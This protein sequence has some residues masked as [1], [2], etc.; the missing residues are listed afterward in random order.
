MNFDNHPVFQLRKKHVRVGIRPVIDGRR[1]GVRES[2]E[3]QTMQMAKKTADLIQNTLRYSDGMPVE[4]VI[5]DICIGGA[6]EA[7]ACMEKFKENNVGVS[8][9]VTPCWCYGTEVMDITPIIPKAVWGFNGT[10]RPGAVYLAAAL[11]GYNQLGVP[12]FGIYGKDVQES[13]DSSIPDDVKEKL[14]LFTKAAIAAMEMQGKSYLS[15]GAV[16]MGIAGSVVD[17]HFIYDYL[18]MKSEFVDMTE[19]IRRI[20]EKIYDSEEFNK[21]IKWVAANCRE[22][23][24]PND[25]PVSGEQRK[26]EWETVVKMTMIFRDLMVGNPKLAELGFEEEALG[27]NAIAAGF[28]GQRQWTDFMPNGDFLEAILNSSFDWNGIRE[29]YIVATENDSLNGICMLFGLLLTN[30]AQIFSDV[31]T[32]W[33]PEAVQ[34]VG[35][36]KLTGLAEGGIIH[37]INSGSSALDGTGKQRLDGKPAIKPFWEITEKEA[38]DCLEATSWCP[39]IREYFRGGGFSSHFLTEG[40]MPVTM[41]RINIIHGLGP[42]LQIAEG[43]TVELDPEIDAL[44]QKRTNPTWPT[45]WFVPKITGKGAF[46]DVYSV[47][48]NWGANHAA[49][50]Y[51][52]IGDKLITLA[53]ILRIPVY[54]HNIERDRIFRPAAWN[55][56]GTSDAESADFAACKSFGPLY[57]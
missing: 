15:V 12:A 5:A 14:L 36:K 45:T 3:A 16:S 49:V 18:G 24:D 11:A 43:Y 44:L 46:K 6:A 53:S 30:T 1:K 17:T 47:M 52:H 23:E 35:G 34:R 41:S 42:A 21:A 13:D 4:C 29:P 26:S 19:I 28:Q 48:L 7:A 40:G 22:G 37:L 38:K 39:A 57:R 55:A 25:P 32:Y 51:G 54:M 33:S 8:I 56:F 50:S 9:T 10:E 20:N 2:L 31:R 27:H